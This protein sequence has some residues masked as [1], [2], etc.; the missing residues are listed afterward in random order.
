M[1]GRIE[2]PGALSRFLSRFAARSGQ[3]AVVF[4]WFVPSDR[5]RGRPGGDRGSTGGP[6][7]RIIFS[8]HDNRGHR[9]GRAVP[10]VIAGAL[11]QP[12]LVVGAV[13]DLDQ[14][15]FLRVWQDEKK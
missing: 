3:S 5:R 12:A 7:R 9:H 15:V 1:D 8:H 2:T 13:C 11:A 4:A 6:V 14:A 10:G